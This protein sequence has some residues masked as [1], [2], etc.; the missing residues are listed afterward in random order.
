MKLPVF[1]LCT[2]SV[3]EH[4]VLL[5][6]A[7]PRREMMFCAH[8]RKRRVPSPTAPPLEGP[9]GSGWIQGPDL[10]ADAGDRASGRYRRLIQGEDPS[11]GV[12]PV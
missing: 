10:E 9:G 5:P 2:G 4:G 12:E 3:L 7:P 11:L 8:V 6:P 1:P